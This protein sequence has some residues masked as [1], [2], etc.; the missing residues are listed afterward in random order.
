MTL[1][2]ATIVWV[3]FASEFACQ[4]RKTTVIF[5]SVAYPSPQRTD[6]TVLFLVGKPF[7]EII[8][9]SGLWYMAELGTDF[10]MSDVPYQP[11]IPGT[12]HDKCST[13]TNF[14]VKQE[15][16]RVKYLLRMFWV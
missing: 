9:I 12:Y 7:M 14:T 11:F 4:K 5:L 10:G 8:V 2:V 3:Y 13:S 15:V 1:S 6:D 16:E